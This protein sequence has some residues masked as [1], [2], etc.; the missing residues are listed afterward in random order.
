MAIGSRIAHD[1]PAAEGYLRRHECDV[2]LIDMK[3]PAQGDGMAVLEA[4]QNQNPAARTLLITGFAKEMHG[5]IDRALESGASAVCYKPFDVG[6]LLQT[7][8]RLARHVGLKGRSACNELANPLRRNRRQ[9]HARLAPLV[10][11][12]DPDTRP[13]CRTSR[14]GRLAAW[15]PPVRSGFARSRRLVGGCG[16]HSRP[17]PAR[18][19]CRAN[20]CAST[21]AGSQA[22]VIIVTGF[23][24]LNDAILALRAA[25]R[26]LLKPVNPDALRASICRIVEQQ[27]TARKLHVSQE[28]LRREHDFAE[29]L[30]ETAQMIVLLRNTH[31]HI[32]R[33]NRYF[34]E[35]TQ[36]SLEEVRDGAG[37]D[38]FLSVA[39]RT[40]AEDLFRRALREGRLDWTSTIVTKGGESR[41]IHWS[42]KTLLDAAGQTVGLL[43][44]GLDITDLEE[45]Q[46]RA[47]QSERLAAIG[48]MMAGLAHE[49]GNA[50]TAEPGAA[51]KCWPWMWRTGR[52]RSTWSPACNL[53]KTISGRCTRK[54]ASMRPRSSCERENLQP[55]PGFGGSFGKLGTAA[56]GARQTR[57]RRGDGPRQ[58]GWSSI[59]FACGQVF[60]NVLENALGRCNDPVEITV[61]ARDVRQGT[62]CCADR[63]A[64]Q[65][66]GLSKEQRQADF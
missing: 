13:T 61:A 66:P 27:Q 33:F 52:R 16:R 59:R 35:L 42:S 11:E 54:S 9:P 48:Q 63:I 28:R 22:A 15:K 29:G 2:V 40:A 39:D 6:Q 17:P 10:V 38:P 41:R 60:H 50:L 47:L 4:V 30:I 7:V 46:R 32:V 12:D 26:I 53:P 62:A 24:D 57:L 49:S 43:T 5:L 23:A 64:D 1:A 21:P 65:G 51:W 14:A 31:G 3:L 37:N 20:P 36:Y 44:C 25:A 58:P 55:A 18:R 34:A 45:A 8:D 56:H 19:P